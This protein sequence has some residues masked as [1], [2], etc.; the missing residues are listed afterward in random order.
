MKLYKRIVVVT[1]GR[2]YEDMQMVNEVLEF[3]SPD[4]VVQ[5]GATGA[6]RLAKEWADDNMVAGITVEAHWTEHGKAAGPIR[7]REML[8]SYPK[9]IVVAFRGGRGTENCIKTAVS[10][11]MIVLRVEP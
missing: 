11:N 6:D 10:L 2:D 3:L 4:L 5:G 9:A 1:G 7:N 8:K